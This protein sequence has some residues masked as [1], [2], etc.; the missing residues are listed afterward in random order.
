M[1]K[2]QE[3]LQILALE[4]LPAG[5]EIDGQPLGLVGVEHALGHIHVHT[6]EGIAKMLNGVEIDND[7]MV[8]RR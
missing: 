6:T 1:A 2:A 4:Q 7:V 8:N 5:V 3:A